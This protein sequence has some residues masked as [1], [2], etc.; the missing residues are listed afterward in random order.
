M[1]ILC[2]YYITLRCNSKCGFC[3]IWS[4]EKYR[5]LKEQS[6]EEIKQNLL[7]LK[8]LGVKFI[9]FT[10]GEPLLSENLIEALKFAKK[11]NFITTVTTNTILYPHF[12]EKLKGLVDSL[13]FSFD[14]PYRQA[15]DRVRGVKCYD[16]FIQ[17]LETAKKIQ[18]KVTL[19]H[20]ITDENVHELDEI[21][22]FAQNRRTPIKL[23]P[24]FSYF[25]NSGL[26]VKYIDI[27]KNA[28]KE[29]YVCADLAHLEFIKDGGNKTSRPLCKAI[30]SCVVISP[31]NCL[32][33]PCYHKCSHKLKIDN[34][35]CELYFSAQTREMKKN[36][37]KWKF[38]E[39][40]AIYC[41]MRS[42]FYRSFPSRY[43]FL[44]FKS[45]IKLIREWIRP[46]F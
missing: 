9:D 43:F 31:D 14:S 46:Q 1:P 16:S 20:T 25:D 5:D 12:A 30:S 13:V 7:A 39:N 22:K 19:L 33:L 2:N 32:M 37:G 17:S 26:H 23:N 36:E 24:C 28:Q 34:N 3:N 15:H 18:Q 44:Y 4:N 40:C 42:S 6:L 10:G 45:Q 8:K 21:I 38:C 27:L 29:P 41:Y 11:L 35:L